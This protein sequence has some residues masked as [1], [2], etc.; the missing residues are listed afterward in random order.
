MGLS[1]GEDAVFFVDDRY[2]PMAPK[3]KAAIAALTNMP[4]QFV[5]NPT[6]RR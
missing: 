4:V 2:A 6:S 1:V 5:L 3:I